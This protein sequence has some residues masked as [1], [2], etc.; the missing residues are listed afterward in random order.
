MADAF[1]GNIEE[2]Y[3][4]VGCSRNPSCLDWGLNGL[5]AFAAS[6]SVAIYLPEVRDYN[7][8]R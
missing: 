4:S 8:S 7:L 2:N 1:G 5:V 6:N 3:I